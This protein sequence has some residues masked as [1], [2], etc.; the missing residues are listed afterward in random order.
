MAKRFM[1]VCFGLLALALA[2]HLGAKNASAQ[3][4]PYHFVGW[5]NL[6]VVGDQAWQLGA[7]GWTQR[8]PQDLPPVPPSTLVWWEDQPRG[9]GGMIALTENGEGWSSGGPGGW[10]S[11]GFPPGGPTPTRQQSWGQVKAKYHN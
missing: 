8:F 3:A 11:V 1:F 5:G 7:G 4:P 10:V 6:V 2:Y 9:A